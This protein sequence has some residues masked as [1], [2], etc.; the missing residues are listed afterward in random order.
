M[1]LRAVRGSSR[2][3]GRACGGGVGGDD[4]RDWE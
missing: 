4:D 3:S 1:D 2:G